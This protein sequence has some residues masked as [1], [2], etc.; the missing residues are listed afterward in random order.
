[1]DIHISHV[2]CDAVVA[3]SGCVARHKVPT[4]SNMCNGNHALVDRVPL[5][6]WRYELTN[7]GIPKGP[8]TDIMKTLDFYGGVC[9]CGWGQVLRI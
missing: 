9:H 5:T 7:W 4:D 8:S 3:A 1:M 2:L 6:F